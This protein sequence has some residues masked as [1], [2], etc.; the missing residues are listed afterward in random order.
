MSDVQ[1]ISVLRWMES[2]VL[3]LEDWAVPLSQCLQLARGVQRQQEG[4][5]QQGTVLQPR[6]MQQ[7]QV[8]VLL[9]QEQASQQ[10]RQQELMQTGPGAG[11]GAQERGSMPSE[12]VAGPAR[13]VAQVVA[14]PAQAVAG[15]PQQAGP[16]RPPVT[17]STSM[18][19]LSS[20]EELL[21]NGGD[22]R[23]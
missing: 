13:P 10:R 12:A 14:G 21:L 6:N 1:L 11:T 7:Q 22:G 19:S 2:G 17:T 20:I 23:N 4:Q 9:A 15:R 5:Q 18:L 16:A 8:A 3:R